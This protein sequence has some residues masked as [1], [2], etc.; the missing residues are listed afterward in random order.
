[1]S[2]LNYTAIVRTTAGVDVKRAAISA[3]SAAAAGNELVAAVSGKKICVL[4]VVLIANADVTATFYSGP[5]DTGTA[6]SGPL[7]LG[8]KGGFAVD[9]PADPQMHAMET[10]AGARLSLLLSAAVQC[11][12]WLTYYEE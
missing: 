2:I 10:A 8:A 6:I 4:G 7:P 3:A 11:S 12:G 9:A 1:M 5:A